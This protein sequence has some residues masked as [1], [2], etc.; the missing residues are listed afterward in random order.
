MK[1]LTTQIAHICEWMSQRPTKHV[2]AKQ[3]IMSNQL[4]R[5]LHPKW[6]Q[7]NKKHEELS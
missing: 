2:T 6:Q 4:H 7:Q 3:V 5:Y 1:Q